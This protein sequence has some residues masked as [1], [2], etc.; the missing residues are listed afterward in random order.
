MGNLYN[1]AG[2]MNNIF[3]GML[4]VFLN[5]NLDIGPSRIGLIPNFL[6][7]VFMLKGITELSTLSKR[8]LKVEP[9]TKAIA[10]YSGICYAMDTFGI[11]SMLGELLAF[12]LGLLTTIFSLIISHGIV[13]GIL[14]IELTKAQ[15]LNANN[16][17]STWR[18]LAGFSLVTFLLYF[19]PLL[20]VISIIAGFIVGIYYL[21]VFNQ[22][23]K[24]FYEQN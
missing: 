9:L 7:Y 4:L 24:L 21:F 13:M 20:A 14:D 19:I 18:L 23:K 10:I 8:F 17:Y 11:T 6:G 22:T 1:A 12:I 16:L 3:I 15:N 5:F 2:I